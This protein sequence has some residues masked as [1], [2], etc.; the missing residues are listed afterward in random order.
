MKPVGAP[1]GQLQTKINF[2]GRKG[3][4]NGEGKVEK[5]ALRL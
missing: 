5:A 1:F 3:N 2:A 4:H